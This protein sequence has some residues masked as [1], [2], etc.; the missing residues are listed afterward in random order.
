MAHVISRVF[1]VVQS[2]GRKGQAASGVR[3]FEKSSKDLS[4]LHAGQRLN[5]PYPNAK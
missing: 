2:V 5:V 3:C 4:S 1:F